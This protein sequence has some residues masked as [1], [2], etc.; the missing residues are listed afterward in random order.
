MR[1]KVTAE[2]GALVF[3]DEGYVWRLF[4]YDLPLPVGLLL[5]TGYIEERPLDD[6]SFSMRMTLQ[7]PLFGELFRYSGVFALPEEGMVIDGSV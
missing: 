2:E 5:G 1:F 4:G 3:R 6:R 7:H